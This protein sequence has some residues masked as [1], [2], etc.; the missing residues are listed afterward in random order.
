LAPKPLMTEFRKAHQFI[1]F[2]V[3]QP[4]QC[5]LADFM[6]AHPEF[7]EQL[8]GFYHARRDALRAELAGT[9]LSILPCQA[10]YFQLVDYSAVSSL[11][12]MEFAL[13]L[14]RQIGVAT[15]PVSVFTPESD[16]DCSPR[17]VRLCFAKSDATLAEAGN[18]LRRLASADFFK[19]N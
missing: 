14:T 11:P 9:G 5:A 10:T 16:P 12:D 8:A 19:P 13:W 4:M 17:V 1:V 2:V 3:N 6:G 15:I 18:R 7:A